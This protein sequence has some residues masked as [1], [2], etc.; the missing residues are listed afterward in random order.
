MFEVLDIFPARL[1][2]AHLG[3]PITSG[4]LAATRLQ[5]SND[6]KLSD[7]R[8]VLNMPELGDIRK[9]ISDAC[10]D[11]ID[12]AYAPSTELDFFITQSWFTYLQSDEDIH[13]HRHSNCLFTGTFYF[14][15]EPGDAIS[16]HADRFHQISI[17]SNEPR[18]RELY[19]KDIG[20]VPGLLIFF[21]SYLTHSVPAV[22][23][24]RERICM[25]FNVF[26]KGHYGN[27]S[28]YSALYI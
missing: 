20:I 5:K 3:R 17:D 24:T 11:Y 14:D 8:Y 4:E 15:C 6:P 16:F 27:E 23:R 25:A 13:Q 21:P 28:T 2:I 22:K 9:F 26:A 10:R 18:V 12:V 1:G 7:E 19:H